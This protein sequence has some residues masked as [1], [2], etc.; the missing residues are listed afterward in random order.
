MAFGAPRTKAVAVEQ[1][2]IPYHFKAS[3][4][5]SI[6]FGLPAMLTCWMLALPHC[7]VLTLLPLLLLVVGLLQ[8]L[9][10]HAPGTLS[11]KYDLIL[12]RVHVLPLDMW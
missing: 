12:G 4:C 6:C 11:T 7:H 2:E 1:F 3:A 8:I 5:P 9:T 10:L